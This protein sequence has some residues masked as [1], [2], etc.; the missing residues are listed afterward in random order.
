MSDPDG[1][2]GPRDETLS[3][4]LSL[5]ETDRELEVI[6]FSDQAEIVGGRLRGPRS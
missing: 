6:V 4:P 5:N 3:F 2:L 1:A